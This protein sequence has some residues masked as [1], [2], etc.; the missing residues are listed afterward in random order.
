MTAQQKQQLEN[1]LKPNEV[2]INLTMTQIEPDFRGFPQFK[3][4]YENPPENY[5]LVRIIA[6]FNVAILENLSYEPP[7]NSN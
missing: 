6:P 3:T 1:L 2:L 5:K 4:V 7:I